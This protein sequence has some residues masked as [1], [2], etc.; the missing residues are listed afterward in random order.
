MEWLYTRKII[1]DPFIRG[2][3]AEV[4][5]GLHPIQHDGIQKLYFL[6]K[7]DAGELAELFGEAP[8][9]ELASVD[10]IRLKEPAGLDFVSA[11]HVVEHI[12]NPIAAIVEWI[13]LIQEGG[14]FYMSVP[15][16]KNSTE[17]GRMC[18][19]IDHILDDYFFDRGVAAYESKQHIY[20]FMLTCGASDGEMRPWYAD[21]STRDFS[22]W[23]LFD[24][25]QRDDHDLHW[26][27][28]DLATA[29]AM[30]DVAFCMAG[31]SAEVLH[32][33]ETKDSHYIVA[34]KAPPSP[35][36]ASLVAF[37]AKIAAALDRCDNAMNEPNA[38]T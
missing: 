5:A 9:Y 29:R 23:I 38:A 18:T 2:V 14:V 25:P 21:N 34:R 28:F 11:H 37:R 1:G 24:V 7:R 35:A 22:R 3:G 6:D 20:S 16:L 36:P 13:S 10:E 30:V 17:M 15:S 4:G 32:C 31:F 33:E 19:P 12:A 27:S 26:H 8:V